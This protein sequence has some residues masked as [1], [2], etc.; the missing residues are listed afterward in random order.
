MFERIERDLE[1]QTALGKLGSG[2]PGNEQG[3]DSHKVLSMRTDY[4]RSA[5]RRPS[6]MLGGFVVRTGKIRCVRLHET[7]QSYDNVVRLSKSELLYDKLPCSE[8]CL[9]LSIFDREA[10]PLLEFRKLAVLTSSTRD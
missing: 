3:T 9:R 4:L 6:A 1:A 8:L 10:S 7:T 2:L 5:I